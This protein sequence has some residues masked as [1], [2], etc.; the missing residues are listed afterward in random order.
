MAGCRVISGTQ[1]D[2]FKGG[3]SRKP[4]CRQKGRGLVISGAQVTGDNKSP[5]LPV[6]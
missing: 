6:F 2:E 4:Y 1:R 3:A 5:K